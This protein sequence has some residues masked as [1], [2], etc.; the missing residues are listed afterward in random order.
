MQ[1]K[2][3]IFNDTGLIRHHRDSSLPRFAEAA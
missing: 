2:L 3:L 1:R